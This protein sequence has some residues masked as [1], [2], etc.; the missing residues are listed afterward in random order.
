M[1]AVAADLVL[2]QLMPCGPPE[3]PH[4][5]KAT[6]EVLVLSHHQRVVV[7]VVAAVVLAL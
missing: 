4:L 7:L 1:Q 2:L 5:A 6:L 3:M